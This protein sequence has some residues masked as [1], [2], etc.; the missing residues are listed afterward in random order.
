MDWAAVAGWAA[1]VVVAWVV[2]AEQDLGAGAWAEVASGGVVS[3][4]AVTVAAEVMV[5]AA[6]AAVAT[7]MAAAVMASAAAG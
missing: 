7:G 6:V 1:A 2:G 4:G 5:A 3:V